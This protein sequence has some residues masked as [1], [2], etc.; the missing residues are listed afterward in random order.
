MKRVDIRLQRNSRTMLL[1]D[2]CF[3]VLTRPYYLLLRVTTVSTIEA[4]VH[5]QMH[6]RS[7]SYQT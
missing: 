3:V 6:A 7:S 2:H 1:P 4:N 5:C